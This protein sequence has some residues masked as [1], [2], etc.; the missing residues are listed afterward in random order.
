MSMSG[1]EWPNMWPNSLLFIL[2]SYQ[3]HS[4]KVSSKSDESNSRY[5]ENCIFWDQK[6]PNLGL[7]DGHAWTRIGEHVTKLITLHPFHTKNISSKFH[8]N[9]MNQNRNM[10]ENIHFGPDQPN[11]PP[12]T[13]A[14]FAQK[15]GK[16]I[17]FWKI[18][19]DHFLPLI[20]L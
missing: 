5:I 13:F 16:G 20:V 12:P 18:V 15:K 11:C 1:Q 6:W 10:L 17:F 8:R 2:L 7:N 9:L 4:L 14:L 3:E 19:F